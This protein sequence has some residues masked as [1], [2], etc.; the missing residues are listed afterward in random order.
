MPATR[1]NSLLTVTFQ[2]LYLG[3]ALRVPGL[4]VNIISEGVLQQQRCKVISQND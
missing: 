3:E 2:G 4:E 1:L